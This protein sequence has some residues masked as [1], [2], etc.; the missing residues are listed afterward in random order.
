[1]TANSKRFLVLPLILLFIFTACDSDNNSNAQ[2]MSDPDACPCFSAQ[3]IRDD[4]MG[5]DF[6]GCTVGPSALATSLDLSEGQTEFS[7]QVNCPDADFGICQCSDGVRDTVSN[8]VTKEQFFDCTDI[9]VDAIVNE[10][11]Q[12]SMSMCLISQ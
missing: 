9:L 1:M 6:F 7:I 11:G 12:Q 2:D 3:D 10:F 4:A 8:N 5:R